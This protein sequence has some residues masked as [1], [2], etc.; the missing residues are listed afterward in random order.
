MNNKDQLSEVFVQ[1]LEQAIDSVVVI[2]PA[3]N[4]ILFNKS[5]ESLWG[6]SRE[7]V[8]GKNVNVLVPDNIKPHHDSYVNANRETGV[9]KI[10]GSTR[11]IE[12]NRKDG[13]VR[14]GSF[15]ISKVEIN[16]EILY[17][18]FIKDVTEEVIERK[19]I[20][21]LSLVT[22]QTDNAI[23][24]TDSDWK[25]IYAN[26]G[27]QKILGYSEQD[28]LGK[29]P[30]QMMAVHY[31]EVRVVQGR[32]ALQK[33]I[34][35]HLEEL[36]KTK[37]GRN[38]W[39][40]VMSN[41]VFDAAGQFQN[42]VTIMSEITN[43]KLHEVIHSKVLALIARDEPLEVAM[44]HACNEVSDVDEALYP[45]VFKVDKQRKLQLLAAPRLPNSYR[46]AFN[47]LRIA[48][49]AAS[50]G[51]AALRGEM[52]DVSD[53]SSDPLWQ[54]FK[55]VML[56]YGLVS[57]CSTPIKNKAGE[58]IGIISF[59]RKQRQAMSELDKALV[60]ILSPLCALAIE[61]EEHQQNI[62]QLAYYDGLTKLPNRSLLHAKAEQEVRDA[63]AN[64]STLA[65][66][67]LDLDRFK[68]VNDS[69]GHPAGDQFLK[70]I[71]ER[72]K[73]RCQS[74]E[75]YGRLSGDEFVVV[76][77]NTNHEHIGH[78]VEELKNY[79]SA[80]VE[81]NNAK[82]VP[83]VSIGVS[84]YPDDGHDVGT[85]LHRADMAMYQAKIAG[86]GRF[87]F[88][89]HELNQLAQEKQ[90]L[91][92]AL[93]EAI[94]QGQLELAYQPQINMKDGSLYGV[95]ALARWHHPKF[96]S[97]SPGK[98]IPLAEECGL[99]GELSRWALHE[100]CQQMATWRR[101][102]VA[103]PA[104][105][106][107]LSPLNFHNMDL[108][109]LVM[110]ELSDNKLKSSDLTLELTESVLLDTNPNTL[111]VLHD[112]H[113]NGIGF[114]ID[115]FGT[116]YS[117]LSYLRKIPI[118]ELKLDRSFVI[119]LEYDKTSRALSQA[120]LQIGKSLELDV[121]AEGIEEQAQYNVLKSQGFHVAQG[122]LFSKPLN[123]TEIETWISNITDLSAL[124]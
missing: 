4:I 111:K 36:V 42:M 117:S 92:L 10:V 57:C 61:R 91:E 62:R 59:A 58:V 94:E 7:E 100:A 21:M 44:E 20:E 96:G 54:N 108:C 103:I 70:T 5:A 98:F 76:L 107:N 64:G 77:P 22:D 50:S 34:S 32:K 124:D 52:V 1:T 11:D 112:I 68:Q 47:G 41:P 27:L 38:V 95:E 55:H 114:S 14:W 90:E 104:V 48:E 106:I 69:F 39:C 35:L 120:V 33:G 37:S 93:Q 73:G 109:D 56:P 82:V 81:I 60:N 66:L 28:L 97:I 46:K 40:S 122:F 15:S 3:N 79:I 17:T 9:N 8:L 116:G 26:N 25:V 85:L 74:S 99:I 23:L 16:G 84:I 121:V 118:K 51:T 86:K 123:A 72:I 6:Y 24:I 67:F 13:T 31:D 105:S 102:N 45:A 110:K 87:A 113:D 115:D 29:T 63:A 30:T 19:R 88:F 119:D 78:F 89:S 18:A 53:I 49:G 75:I 71:A 101:K 80:P 12:I 2:N 83:S 43:A 65:I